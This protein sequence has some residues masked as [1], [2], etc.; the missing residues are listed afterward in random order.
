VLLGEDRHVAIVPQAGR[1]GNPPD[2]RTRAAGASTSRGTPYSRT[3]GGSL[4]S[5]CA[6][7]K[8]RAAATVRSH[9]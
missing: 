4:R 5:G 1:A 9:S 3:P 7:R 2:G 8:A 6:A